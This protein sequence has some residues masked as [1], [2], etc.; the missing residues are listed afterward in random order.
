M[1]GYAAADKATFIAITPEYLEY[2]ENDSTLDQDKKDRRR[3]LVETWKLR[4]DNTIDAGET[5]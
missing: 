5:P 4:I 3:R 2:V 1:K